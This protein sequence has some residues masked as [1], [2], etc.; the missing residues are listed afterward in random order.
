MA[1]PR[2]RRRATSGFAH[3]DL[4]RNGSRLLANRW[5]H[6]KGGNSLHRD[7]GLNHRF[8]TRPPLPRHSAAEVVIAKNHDKN[9]GIT[10]KIQTSKPARQNTNAQG[11]TRYA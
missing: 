8:N 1:A 11:R 7:I 4:F 3:P 9:S 6:P 10:L 2:I 5:H